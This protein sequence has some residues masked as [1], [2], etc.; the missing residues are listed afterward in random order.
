MTDATLPKTKLIGKNLVGF[1]ITNKTVENCCEKDKSAAAAK[2][3]A[4]K[5][6]AIK[7]GLRRA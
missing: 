4:V 1:D 5:I 2:I 7:P 3:T 6:G